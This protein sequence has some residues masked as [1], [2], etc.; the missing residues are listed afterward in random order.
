MLVHIFGENVWREIKLIQ[1]EKECLLDDVLSPIV[2]TGVSL[3]WPFKSL[4]RTGLSLMSD[5]VEASVKLMLV[6]HNNSPKYWRTVGRMGVKVLLTS[7][8]SACT[9]IFTKWHKARQSYTKRRDPFHIQYRPDYSHQTT[10][11]GS[12]YAINHLFHSLVNP[13][14]HN[15]MDWCT[16]A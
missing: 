13:R 2:T 7:V 15:T 4:E 9:I 14:T 1:I 11:A 8:T 10:K 3:V 6:L 16:S 12:G 5:W